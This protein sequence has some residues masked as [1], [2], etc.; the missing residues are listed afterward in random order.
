MRK[1]T[2]IATAAM[3]IGA[4]AALAAPLP[5]ASGPGMKGMNDNPIVSVKHKKRHKKSRMGGMDGQPGNPN[6]PA[7]A[8]MQGGATQ[9]SGSMGGG[10]GMG[11]APTSGTSR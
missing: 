1:L 10:G 4:Q 11:G 8:P 6:M 9:G 5:T 7:G 3:F 2:L